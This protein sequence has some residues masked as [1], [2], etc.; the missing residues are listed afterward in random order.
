M[1]LCAT[2]GAD[3]A[4][5]LRWMLARL[6]PFTAGIP[7]GKKLRAAIADCTT[8]SDLKAVLETA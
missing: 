1:K 7:G 2:R 6:F 8:L 3:G 5:N 4:Q